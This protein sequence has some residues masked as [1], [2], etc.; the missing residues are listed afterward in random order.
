MAL[1]KAIRFCIILRISSPGV[2]RFG[3]HLLRFKS[4]TFSTI[5][6]TQKQQD[7]NNAKQYQIQNSKSNHHFHFSLCS[8]KELNLYCIVTPQKSKINYIFCL[9][10][11]VLTAA[12]CAIC[13][14]GLFGSF[15][16]SKC[17]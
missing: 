3:T 5:G 2:L 15:S 8:N 1:L 9:I 17:S 4:T 13:I 12:F 16:V 14:F 7:A 11:P 6:Q 10:S